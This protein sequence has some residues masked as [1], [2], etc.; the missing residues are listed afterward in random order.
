[1]PLTESSIQTSSVLYGANNQAVTITLTSLASAAAR[2][3][4]SIS[5]TTN[6]YEDVYLFIKITTN[7]AGTSATGYVNV[8]G[9]GTVDGGTTYPEAIT[10]T[11]AAVTLTTPPNLVLLAQLNANTNAATKTYG[12]FS[13]C[14]NYGLDRLPAIWGVV[15]V[16]Q[17][18]A[19]FNATASN[20]AVTYQGLNGQLV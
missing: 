20:Y 2:A 13:F 1:M 14:R 7:A 6:L 12:P 10:G 5:N 17:T 16:N 4:T 3:S 9:Y 8:Y 19:A 18:G 15:V 11:D